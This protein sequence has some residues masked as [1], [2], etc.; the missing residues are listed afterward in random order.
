MARYSYRLTHHV[1]SHALRVRH[2]FGHQLT[3]TRKEQENHTR[4]LGYSVHRQQCLIRVNLCLLSLLHARA[5]VRLKII[6]L[7]KI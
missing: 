1:N 5:R 7:L 4:Y 6:I 3:L 2:A